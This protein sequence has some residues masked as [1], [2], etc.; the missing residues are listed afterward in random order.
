MPKPKTQRTATLPDGSITSRLTAAERAYIVITRLSYEYHLA[1]ASHIYE[2]E[3]AIYRDYCAEIN[4]TSVWQNRRRGSSDEEHAARIAARKAH[5][6]K[7]IKGIASAHDYQMRCRA[8][9]IADVERRKANGLYDRWNVKAWFG[10][11]EQAR[12]AADAP[13]PP[14]IAEVR[15]IHTE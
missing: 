6:T 14:R 8:K 7:A 5:A 9:R 10:S 1:E 15:I 11:M 4:G 3:G 2:V 12:K 13:R